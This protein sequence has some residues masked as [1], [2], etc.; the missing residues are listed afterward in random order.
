MFCQISAM[1]ISLFQIWIYKCAYIVK[2]IVITGI[3]PIAI[4]VIFAAC[5]KPSTIEVKN[6][7]RTDTIEKVFWGEILIDYEILPSA[8]SGKV[9]LYE[10]AQYNLNFPEEFPIIFS[11]SIKGKEFRFKTNQSY[12][13]G[14]EDYLLITLN[15]STQVSELKE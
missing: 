1:K 13:L 10:D 9:K 12:K 11:L 7:F 15:D 6:D 8:S 5:N 2:N 3:I 4:I 14:K